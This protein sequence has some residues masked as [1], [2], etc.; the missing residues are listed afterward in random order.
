MRGRSVATWWLPVGAMFTGLAML[1]GGSAWGAATAEPA[2]SLHERSQPML[3]AGPVEHIG[4]PRVVGR[5]PAVVADD[6]GRVDVVW[7]SVQTVNHERV[8][9]TWTAHRSPAGTWSDPRTMVCSPA[10]VCGTGRPHLGVDAIGDVTAVWM[11]SSAVIAAE[12]PAGGRWGAAGIIAA[13]PAGHS[14][15][16]LAVSGNGA[17]FVTFIA[18]V[19]SCRTEVV[20][21]TSEGVWGQPV[22]LSPGSS[23]TF[24]YARLGY[25]AASSGGRAVV[26]VRRIGT[27]GESSFWAYRFVPRRGW[28]DPQRLTSAS[29][30]SG[31]VVAMGD[32]GEAVALFPR[33][34]WRQ[35]R[36]SIVERHMSAR[37]AWGRVRPVSSVG[38][39]G[40][41]FFGVV[42]DSAG[43]ETVSWI[44]GSPTGHL[45]GMVARRVV[46]GSWRKT[47]L[48]DRVSSLRPPMVNRHNDVLLCS[49][50][51][52]VMWRPMAG[53][54]AALRSRVSAVS[55]L[56]PN[57]DALR[58]WWVYRSGL[59]AQ[60]IHVSG[61]NVR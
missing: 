6:K 28:Q 5:R 29:E 60:R 4:G 19:T 11:T 14:D 36:W 27:D 54:S 24:G 1:P 8:K 49:S 48:L 22:D 26:T 32:S 42:I 41:Y 47:E 51:W 17:A 39:I 56:M 7:N 15:M 57:G 23:A 44:E 37:G 10:R 40:P 13:K 34:S 2:V 35:E 33:F 30:T 50:R 58:V 31:A 46:G 16:R 53:W 38:P 12:K 20:S 9:E 45:V 25:L 52:T 21:R 18:C 55:A 3:V 61:D 43:T 59:K